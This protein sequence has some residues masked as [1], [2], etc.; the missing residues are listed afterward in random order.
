[1]SIKEK[2]LKSAEALGLKEERKDFYVEGFMDGHLD[3]SLEA[4]HRA[5]DILLTNTKQRLGAD[6]VELR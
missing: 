6:P 5:M 3:G 1:M 4:I 2:A